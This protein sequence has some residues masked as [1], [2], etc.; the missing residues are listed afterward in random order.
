MIGEDA[1]SDG[2]GEKVF[3]FNFADGHIKGYN[4]GRTQE[5][6]SIGKCEVPMFVRCVRGEE[7]IYGVNKSVNNGDGTVTD[8][9]IGLMLSSVNVS[10]MVR[11]N[12][13]S[14]LVR[15]AD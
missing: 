6:K 9:A 11:I 2:A 3:G 15:D 12:N 14:L 10:D 5:G 13:Y 1:A 8:E 4:T 7:G